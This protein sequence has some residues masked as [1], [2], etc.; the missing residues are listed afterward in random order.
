[1]AHQNYRGLFKS[2][3]N[4]VALFSGQKSIIVSLSE[5]LIE[6]QS[7]YD[8]NSLYERQGLHLYQEKS[9][10]REVN[11]THISKRA[12]SSRTVNLVLD[13]N[14][15]LSKQSRTFLTS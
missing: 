10:K 11:F 4:L 14:Q 13:G 3:D 9:E 12:T 2:L 15:P 7:I 8:N 1:M 5:T 6:S